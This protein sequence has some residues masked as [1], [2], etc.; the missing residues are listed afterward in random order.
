MYT[1]NN[2]FI[3]RTNGASNCRW[4]I[5]APHNE[6]AHEVV[7]VLAHGVARFVTSIEAHAETIGCNEFGNETR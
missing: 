3:E 7:V 6:F 1:F 4:A 2:H 5:F